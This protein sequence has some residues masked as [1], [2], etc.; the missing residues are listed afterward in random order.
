[1]VG[2]QGGRGHPTEWERSDQGHCQVE[3]LKERPHHYNS[4]VDGIVTNYF[5]LE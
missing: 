3:G 5:H 2:V 4:V 1:M